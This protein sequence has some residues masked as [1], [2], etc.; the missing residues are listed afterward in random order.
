MKTVLITGGSRGIGRAC[1]ELFAASGYNVAFTYKNS[2]NEA[3]S[4]A[5]RI[6]ALAICADSAVEED[7]INAVSRT[8][9]AYG[10]IDC[11]INNAGISSFSIFT[12]LTLS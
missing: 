12:E 7:V 9:S 4:L 3:K 6:G 10:K 2:E 8:L 11:L 5:E 1:A